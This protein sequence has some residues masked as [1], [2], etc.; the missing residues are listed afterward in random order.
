MQLPARIEDWFR[1]LAMRSRFDDLWPDLRRFEKLPEVFSNELMP[2]INLAESEK[3]VVVTLEAPGMEESDFDIHVV[4]NQLTI[5][6]EKKF[7]E[8][9]DDKEFR[10]VEIEYGKFSR[11][12]TLPAAVRTDDIDAVYHNGVLTI[13]IAKLEPTPTKKIKIRTE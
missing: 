10:R 9:T 11:T 12:M 6:G 3:S 5:N 2:P 4:G 13:K 7:E 1:P 8:K